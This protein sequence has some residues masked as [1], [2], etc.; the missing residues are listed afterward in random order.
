M[1]IFISLTQWIYIYLWVDGVRL[2]LVHLSI[3]SILLLNLSK[4]I[5]RIKNI[6]LT[7]MGKKAT[8]LPRFM[9]KTRIPSHFYSCS[10]EGRKTFF[11]QSLTK[12][13]TFLF[14]IK[15]SRGS[16]SLYNVIKNM[17]ISFILARANPLFSLFHPV[18]TRL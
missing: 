1:H 8:W 11:Q 3:K 6:F 7:F 16:S 10:R 14:L 2:H 9:R 18:N 13:K 4:F 17:K 5:P 12:K 15:V